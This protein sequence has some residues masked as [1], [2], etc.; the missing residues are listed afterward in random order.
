MAQNKRLDARVIEARTTIRWDFPLNY[1]SAKWKFSVNQ[2]N[3]SVLA[4]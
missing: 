2:T 1:I 4:L 3:L